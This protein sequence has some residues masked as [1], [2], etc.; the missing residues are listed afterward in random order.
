[1]AEPA[2]PAST[3]P[4]RLYAV[5]IYARRASP[6]DTDIVFTSLAILAVSSPEAMGKAI[7]RAMAIWPAKDGWSNH[8]AVV[9][10]IPADMITQVRP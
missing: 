7:M 9:T 3:V 4:L 8:K 1:M 2:T 6:I 5:A 10:E